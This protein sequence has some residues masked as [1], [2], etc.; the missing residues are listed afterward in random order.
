[1]VLVE[2]EKKEKKEEIQEFSEGKQIELLDYL[3]ELEQKS[4]RSKYP[5]PRL[6]KKYLDKEGWWDDYHY[7]EEEKPEH[8]DV[9]WGIKL[10]NDTY[11]Y[12]Y[13]AWYSN[14]WHSWDTWFKKWIEIDNDQIL[15][16]CGIPSLYLQTDASLKDRL[17]IG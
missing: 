13:Y 6:T 9:Y 5:I 3:A 11:I 4:I 10:W 12:G 1:M 8:S 16:W 17:A 7:F 14:K 15:A 2:R